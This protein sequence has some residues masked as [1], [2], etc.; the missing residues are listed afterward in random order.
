[1]R[2]SVLCAVVIAFAA[3]TTSFVCAQSSSVQAGANVG[4]DK[5]YGNNNVGGFAAGDSSASGKAK[6]AAGPSSALVTANGNAAGSEM[7]KNKS[8]NT[9]SNSDVQSRATSSGERT[10]SIVEGKASQGSFGQIGN[11]NNSAEAGS[12][13]TGMYKATIRAPGESLAKG[14]GKSSGN[15]SASVHDTAD[16][17]STL[18]HT[19]SQ[20]SASAAKCGCG[21]GSTKAIASGHGV[22]DAGSFLGGGK[23]DM[24]SAGAVVAG[25]ASY[26]GTGT[27]TASGSLDLNGETSVKKSGSNVSAS[28][29][30]NASSEGKH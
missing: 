20:S 14:E 30:Q 3:S 22:D 23:N 18:V 28:A 13:S 25:S 19:A 10:H 24:V 27:K 8:F 6:S 29:V 7:V 11:S 2:K 17:R 16:S 5:T 4:V 1:M 9:V 15:T 21:P 12:T 26:N